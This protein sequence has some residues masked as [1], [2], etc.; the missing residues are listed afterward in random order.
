MKN[1]LFFAVY[2]FIVVAMLVLRLLAAPCVF[3]NYVRETM[4]DPAMVK[5]YVFAVKLG[6]W[7]GK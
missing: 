3:L 6:R 1:V 5:L 2:P 7:A 4:L